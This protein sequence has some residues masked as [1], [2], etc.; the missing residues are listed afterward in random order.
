MTPKDFIAA[1]G[2]AAQA[3][4]HTTKVPASFTIAQAAL[5]SAWAKS[6]LATTGFNLFGVKADKS[7]KG[8]TLTLPTI[9][10]IN[11]KRVTVQAVWRKYS[12]WLECLNDH[13]AF[14]LN[15]KR[16]LPAFT[17]MGD[18]EAFA[19]AVAAAGYATDPDYAKKLVSVIRAHNLTT[20]DK[21]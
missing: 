1:I 6:Q 10:F 3:S 13:A 11:S 17:H 7:W 19:G 5:E 9:E 20:F 16:Y 14:L 12:S 18:G 15:N 2:P 8:A 4:M 21:V